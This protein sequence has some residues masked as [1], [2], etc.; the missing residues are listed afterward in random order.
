MASFKILINKD[1]KN[2]VLKG[3]FSDYNSYDEIKQKLIDNSQNSLFKKDNS[4][5]KE[6]EKFLLVFDKDN[7]PDAFF[8]EELY[9]SVWNDST[10]LYLKNKLLVRGIKDKYRFYIEKVDNFKK[11][12]AKENS[13]ILNDALDTYWDKIYSDILSD[14]N[15]VKLEQYEEK[16]EELKNRYKS[17]NNNNINELHENV[18]C[19]N[20][21]K[22]DFSGK[23]FI[24]SECNNFNLCQECEKLIN[25]N[26]IHQ[27]E[28][29]FIQINKPLIIDN[30]FKYS[31]II[32][33]YCKKF[34]KI[35]SSYFDLEITIINN[36]ENDLQNCSLLQVRFGDEYL[37]CE[38]YKIEESVK[39]GDSITIK[40]FLEFPNSNCKCFSGYFRMFT[41]YG[42]P[43]GN[44]VFIQVF[45]ED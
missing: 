8:P 33:N 10:Y 22:K 19:S 21:F 28:H 4:D 15:I 30:Y 45:N 32:G 36:G 41:P 34:K 26:E 43:F 20:C 40:L 35:T 12:R 17:N 23:R 14:I 6:N 39:R 25:E 44:I 24:C 13:E 11:W 7:Q 2:V 42:I 3:D 18:I 1:S 37:N 9:N 31:N 16:F 38:P 5:L 29:V 27:K